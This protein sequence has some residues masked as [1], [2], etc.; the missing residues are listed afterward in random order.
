MIPTQAVRAR[1][2]SKLSSAFDAGGVVRGSYGLGLG[3]AALAEVD[4]ED[5]HRADGEELRLPFLQRP[6][7]EVRAA[8]VLDE[9]ERRLLVV[10]LPGV[11][12]DPAPHRLHAPRR[13][14][15]ETH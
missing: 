8:H 1:T 7:P 4:R 14:P 12:R 9:A 10:E 3:G 5:G 6:V 11:V 2:A 15:D 13:Q